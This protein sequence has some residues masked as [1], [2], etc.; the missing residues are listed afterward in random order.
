MYSDHRVLLESIEF[1]FL[2]FNLN[3]HQT[4]VQNPNPIKTKRIQNRNGGRAADEKDEECGEGIRAD[5][6]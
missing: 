6:N 5:S 2:R 4:L 1:I 3:I